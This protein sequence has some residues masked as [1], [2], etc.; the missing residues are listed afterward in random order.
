MT[1]ATAPAPPRPR[2]TRRQKRRLSLGLQYT[3]FVAAVLV[4][5]LLADWQSLRDN[6][7][8]GEIA[9]AMFPDILTVALKNTVVYTVTGFAAGLLLGLV[10][11]LMRLSSVPPYRWLATAYV[12]VFR[13]LPALLIFIFVGVGVPLAFPGAQIPGGTVGKVALALALVSAAYM[14][15]TVRAGIQAVPRGQVEAAR[16][17]GMSSSRAMVSIVLPQ[18]FRIIIPPLTN[19]LVLLFKDSSLVLFLGVQ[20]GERELTK[21]GRDLASTRANITPILVAGL[22]YLV[23]TVP[24]SYLARRLEARNARALR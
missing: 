9:R 14:A 5:A 15:E 7:A 24:L 2:L 20:L 13:G 17:L 19:E 8:R 6:F 4:L 3:V 23:I 16:S 22:C 18:A 1:T 12:E 21:F 11:A 10:L